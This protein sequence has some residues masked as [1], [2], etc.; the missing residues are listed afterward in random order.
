MNSASFA[1]LDLSTQGGGPAPAAPNTPY[2]G[3]EPRPQAPTKKAARGRLS[4]PCPVSQPGHHLPSATRSFAL[5]AVA[6]RELFADPCRLAGAAAQIIEF[7]ATDV[8]LALHLD[9]CDQ[10]RIR[11]ER[12][13]HALATR[14]L[15]DGEP[16]VEAAIALGDHHAFVRLHALALAF[17][18]VDVDDHRVAGRELGN[19]LVEARNL[20]ALE[21]F[22][23]VH[24]CPFLAS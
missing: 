15:A 23:D 10:W 4:V 3:P 11:L 18:H 6:R 13:L 17:D 1:P 24:G 12:A 14:N 2:S 8:A 19:G 20:L 21:R 16:G 5:A 9:R 7:G 22:D